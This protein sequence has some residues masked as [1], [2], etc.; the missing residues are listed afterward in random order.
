MWGKEQA[1]RALPPLFH[2]LSIDDWPKGADAAPVG[3]S[4]NFS[5]K[6]SR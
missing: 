2:A 5:L 3:P 1:V 4:Y 6:R